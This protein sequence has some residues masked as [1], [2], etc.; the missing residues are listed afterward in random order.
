MKARPLTVA[1]LMALALTSCGASSTSRSP[2][3]ST[4][5]KSTPAIT[6]A[7][8]ELA[9]FR[10]KVTPI[11]C[12]YA[13]NLQSAERRIVQ[14]VGAAEGP[15]NASAPESSQ[16]QYASAMANLANVLETAID[17]FRSVPPPSPIAQEY[18]SFIASLMTV[19]QQASRVARYAAARNYAEIAAM[20]NIS[21]PT[22]GEGVFHNAGVTGCQTPGS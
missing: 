10:A 4:V 7:D 20:E 8:G 6:P 3:Q 17:G 15:I 13:S 5:A 12:E 1:A 19:H 21:P 2:G 14:V 22:A 9:V 16:V 18:Q 11:L